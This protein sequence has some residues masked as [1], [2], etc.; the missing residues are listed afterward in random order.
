MKMSVA[1]THGRST[2]SKSSSAGKKSAD[3]NAG[4]PSCICIEWFYV[5]CKLHTEQPHTRRR[6]GQQEAARYAQT[7]N[8]VKRRHT[9]RA[10]GQERWPSVRTA[11]P[12]HSDTRP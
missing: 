4:S 6:H 10:L 8:D 5:V 2:P 1:V 7:G 12:N 9:D 3:E 11:G